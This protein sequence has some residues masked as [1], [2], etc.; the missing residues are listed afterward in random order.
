MRAAPD[1]LRGLG[2]EPVRIDTPEG[3]AQYAAE[4]RA[5]SVRGQELRA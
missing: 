5:F 3:R 1:D 2:C 4:Q